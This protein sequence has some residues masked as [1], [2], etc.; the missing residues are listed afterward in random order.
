MRYI[1]ILLVIATY[2]LFAFSNKLAD[3]KA[4]NTEGIDISYGATTL[5]S[6]EWLPKK[7]W[8]EYRIKPKFHYKKVWLGLDI[9]FH[10]DEN[11]KLYKGEWDD[12][13]DIIDKIDYLYYN[14]KNA[15]FYLR[16][17]KLKEVTFGT[18]FI[19][20]RYSNC[21]DY[22]LIEKRVG[23]DLGL[24]LPWDDGIEFFINDIDAARIFGFRTYFVPL[25]FV[26][27]GFSYIHD[28]DPL[29]NN[30]S[31]EGLQFIGLDILSPIYKKDKS[32]LYIYE[33]FAKILDYG[34]G[35][36]SGIRWK[37][38]NLILSGEYRYYD[39]DFEPGYFNE[40]YELDSA[41]KYREI[42]SLAN[43]TKFGGYF[44]EAKMH[45][46][47][48]KIKL[49]T[50]LEK[51]TNSG[52]DFHFFSELEI[53]K[54]LF[55]N[56]KLKLSYD[57]KDAHLADFGLDKKNVVIIGN[58]DYSIAKNVNVK[59]EYKRLYD[60]FGIASRASSIH[61]EIKF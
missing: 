42:L 21:I 24:N 8:Y 40:Y 15:P 54:V 57:D 2:N 23:L 25:D 52:R 16:F 9:R 44:A 33:N 32:E 28:K 30:K 20:N 11:N 7:I 46:L 49:R 56:L 17:G 22:P 34:A 39:S 31:P 41:K 53:N 26:E 50:I 55:E 45:F 48:E 47:N 37:W 19:V 59:F 10:L 4:I 60:E 29:K 36:S 35:F 5:D 3:I 18:G 38:K 61:T 13:G 1:F 51:F 27:I 6:V 58:V 12:L 14:T 43:K